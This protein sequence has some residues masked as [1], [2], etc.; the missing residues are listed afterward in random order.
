MSDKN[1]S[2]KSASP[3]MG[4]PLRRLVRP[5]R[6]WI[7]DQRTT[8]EWLVEHGH[9]GGGWTGVDA[10]IKEEFVAI[11]DLLRL[12]SPRGKGSDPSAFCQTCNG[13]GR[14][15]GYDVSKQTVCPRCRGSKYH[16]RPNTQA[17]GR[18]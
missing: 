5:A 6:R 8:Y 2:T 13:H 18:S 16:N 9:N 4:V 17:E 7:N 12:L 10:A 3:R 1:N 11:R 15:G 14:L